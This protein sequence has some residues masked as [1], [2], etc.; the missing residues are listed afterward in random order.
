MTSLLR[1]NSASY[2]ALIWLFVYSAVIPMQLS[3]YVLCIGEDGHVELEF[4]INGCCADIPT[5]HEDH[6]EGHSESDDNHCGDCV[7]LPIFASLNSKLYIISN[8][9]VPQLY[10]TQL[11]STLTIYHSSNNSIPSNNHASVVPPFINPTLITLPT[12]LLLI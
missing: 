9:E 1:K 12:V 4:S 6:T 7:D 10:D 8:N 3:N 2:I 5:H 11:S